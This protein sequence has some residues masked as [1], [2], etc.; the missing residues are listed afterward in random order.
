[1]CWGAPWPTCGRGAVAHT[2]ALWPTHGRPGPRTGAVW[3]THGCPGPHTG[4]LAPTQAPWPTHRRPG[5]GQL[6]CAGAH[7][8]E[9]MSLRLSATLCLHHSLRLGLGLGLRLHLGLPF[10]SR[11]QEYAL[12]SDCR[13]RAAAA[14]LAPVPWCQAGPKGHAAHL[15]AA[16]RGRIDHR[17]R[18][19]PQAPCMRRSWPQTCRRQC[20]HTSTT[21]GGGTSV[22]GG[23]R[24]GACAGIVAF[25]GS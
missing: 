13:G 15:Q 14:L 5:P 3:P 23:N 9:F 22:C 10:S 16:G 25:G 21:G 18:P 12:S 20:V 7:E 24:F 19:R 17:W 6:M 8:V 1:M 2:Q 4:A 11:S